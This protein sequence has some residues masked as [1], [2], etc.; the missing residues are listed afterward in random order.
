MAAFRCACSNQGYSTLETDYFA[1]F[2]LA[3][4]ESRSTYHEVRLTTF[5][6]C[7]PKLVENNL[8]LDDFHFFT[9]LQSHR[10]RSWIIGVSMIV[11][12]IPLGARAS[13]PDLALDANH[14]SFSVPTLYAGD[15]IRIYARIRNV[16]DVD[17]TASVLFYQGGMVIGQSQAV[18]L[19]A[20]GNPDDVF[21]DFTVPTGTFNIRAVLQGSTPQ[22]VNAEN[23][24]AITPLYTAIS[25]ADRD[26]IIDEQDTCVNDAN[27]DQRDA[28]GDGKGDVCDVDDDNDGVIDGDDPAP[29]DATVTGIVVPT[30]AVSPTPA[31]PIPASSAPTVSSQTPSTA[32]ASSNPA[33]VTSQT[34][35]PSS[36]AV[37]ASKFNPFASISKLVVSPFARFTTWQTDWRTYEFT[38]V[39]QP[40]SGVQLSWDFGDGATS[41]QPHI[42]HAFS[43]PGTYT[44]TLAIVNAD[45]SVLS[46]AQVIDVSFFHLENPL[47]LCVIGLLLA[48]VCGCVWAYFALRRRYDQEAF[49][50]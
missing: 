26:G 1:H 8:F 24:S 39:E 22:D 43:G 48:V 6:R 31:T 34:T 3:S 7:A 40:K 27:A 44:V 16:G 33:T 28:D 38:V 30:P 46:D 25:D 14:I 32:S 2:R 19:R 42:T 11:L 9:M 50:E 23:D 45:G 13:S 4:S 20:N 5:P 37:E 17:T 41:V 35:A 12:T 29:E 18:S 15:T 10:F 36:A 21:V 49:H 47:V